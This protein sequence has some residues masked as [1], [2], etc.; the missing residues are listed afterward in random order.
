[1]KYSIASFL[2]LVTL[3]A[4]CT[5]NQ[6]D[7]SGQGSTPEVNFTDQDNWYQSPMFAVMT[8][9]IYE[10]LS[11]Y[12]TWEWEKNL[13]T[14]FDADKFTRQL[15]ES[16]VDYLIFYDKWIDGLVFHDTKTT[17]YKTSRDFIKDV[18]G[19]CL[20][21]DLKLI[22]YYN[23]ISDGN[24]EFIESAARDKFGNIIAFHPIWPTNYATLHHAGFRKKSLAQ[25]EE[26]FSQYQKLDGIWF[27]I[28]SERLYARNQCVKDAFAMRF[29]KPIEKATIKIKP[30]AMD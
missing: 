25:L 30:T 27:D 9:F 5:V 22:L 20:K 14:A 8:G 18:S 21:N 17:D 24:P 2:V 6:Q 1:M 23:A 29:N 4:S 19:G 28:Y 11:D 10:P 13:G 7:N 3:I 16:N 12:T 26:L 15:K